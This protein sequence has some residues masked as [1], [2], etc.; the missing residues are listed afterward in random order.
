MVLEE[1]VSEPQLCHPGSLEQSLCSPHCSCGRVRQCCCLWALD[2]PRLCATL[3]DSILA[4]GQPWKLRFCFS[5]L[6]PSSGADSVPSSPPF[7]FIGENKGPRRTQPFLRF[8]QTCSPGLLC[9]LIFHQ[10][11]PLAQL[12]ELPPA[13]PQLGVPGDQSAVCRPD[14]PPAQGLA[15]AAHRLHG[16]VHGA[17]QAR[18]GLVSA[19]GL[20]WTGSFSPRP[21]LPHGP[22]FRTL[23]G[24][25]PE[26]G[27]E[28]EE[29]R[30]Q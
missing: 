20:H 19:P 3:P 7:A 28:W 13:Q 21:R 9:P 16:E 8:I 2:G 25:A 24:S 5:T 11:A 30:S 23:G 22:H 29:P 6:G 17:P 26:G 4:T 10:E 12:P 27:C 14:P 15:A 18:M 1:I